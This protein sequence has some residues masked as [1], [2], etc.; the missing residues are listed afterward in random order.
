MFHFS[1]DTFSGW[2]SQ[3]VYFSHQSWSIPSTKSWETVPVAGFIC[4]DFAVFAIL[5]HLAAS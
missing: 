1:E 3:I 4:R 5:W 2:A